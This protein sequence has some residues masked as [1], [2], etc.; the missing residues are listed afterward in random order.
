[1][2]WL[3]LSFFAGTFFGVFVI[4]LARAAAVATPRPEQAGITAR[5]VDV[6]VGE[7]AAIQT[8]RWQ[9]FVDGQTEPP[10]KRVSG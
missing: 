8:G 2:V 4:G 5:S 7:P 3:A 1:M 9:K 10:R 6:R